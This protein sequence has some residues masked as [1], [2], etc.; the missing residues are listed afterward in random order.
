MSFSTL[1]SPDESPFYCKHFTAQI[2]L[3]S[4]MFQINPR[5]LNQTHLHECTTL[6]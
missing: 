3:F 2:P 4:E 6:S 5:S 1:F